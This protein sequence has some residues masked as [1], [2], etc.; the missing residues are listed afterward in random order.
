MA[1][2][3]KKKKAETAYLLYQRAD[4]GPRQTHQTNTA[5]NRDFFM[6]NQL[7][8]EERNSLVEVGMPDFIDNR[9]TPI[10]EMMLFFTVGSQP[11]WAAT[12]RDGTDVDLADAISSLMEYSYNISNGKRLIPAVV[13]DCIVESI[14]A[15]V[16]SFDP[17]RDFGKGE[18]VLDY[19][20]HRDVF[21]DPAAID[22]YY[23]DAGWITVRK[24]L[25]KS[26]LKNKLPQFKNKIEG[27]STNIYYTTPYVSERDTS[28]GEILY[29]E[30]VGEKINAITG[31]YD[32][33]ME[34]LETYRKIKKR[35]VKFYMVK[36][37]SQE[38][39]EQISKQI[40]TRVKEMQ[41]EMQVKLKEMVV[42]FT[43]AV[44]SGQ[45]IQERM[46]LEL[47]KAKKSMEA[48]IEK[49]RQQEYSKLR[50][51][52]TQIVESEM[53]LNEFNESKKNEDFSKYLVSAK[54]YYKT[55]IN[56]LVTVG[57]DTYLYE[58]EYDME[59]Y[60]ILLIPAIW[61]NNPY[62]LS[63]VDLMRDKQREINKARQLVIH[64][65]NLSSNVR[66]LV[67]ENQIVDEDDWDENSSKPSGKLVWRDNGTGHAPVQVNPLP[68]N[69]AFFS[70][71]QTSKS[72]LEYS[73]GIPSPSMGIPVKEQQETYRGLVAQD[74]FATRRLKQWIETVFEPWLTLVGKVQFRMCQLF[75]DTEKE[76][77]IVVPNASGD[78]ERQN[79]KI[80]IP[81]YDNMGEIV[82]RINDIKNANYDIEII[83][84]STRPT[85]RMAKEELYWRYYQGQLIDDIA[86]IMETEIKNKE[87]LLKRKSI[88]AQQQQQLQ[89]M[90]EAIKDKEGTI[91]TLER[92]LVQAGI[93]AKIHEADKVIDRQQTQ[94]KEEIK[95]GQRVALNKINEEAK[96][97]KQTVDMFLAEQNTVDKNK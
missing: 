71:L 40:E 60:P 72:D 42:Q 1:K 45:M 31:E 8:K 73:G 88:Y 46:E 38:V 66:W 97:A 76:F 74:E 18:V 84:G 63:F 64:N 39:L 92:Q 14:G 33:D 12:G 67:M 87:A 43:E 79:K 27:A 58:E 68:L 11:R 89:Q 91:E 78:L 3:T 30:E 19:V 32:Y 51:D 55:F 93:K 69:N 48:E 7:T 28:D 5:K 86:M 65:A 61:A 82:G 70:L 96:R 75:Y 52:A 80:N 20:Y 2:E 4:T 77:S 53:P 81:L 13:R 22:T 35:Y 29:P 41:I 10:V 54:E 56:K 34:Y 59:W 16:V 26:A 24:V 94:S 95:A 50:S 49:Y 90:E 37:P 85:N 62:P 25:S 9:I 15:L 83:A 47:D 6:N 44:Q 36:Q 17:D 21:I 57:M 23:Q